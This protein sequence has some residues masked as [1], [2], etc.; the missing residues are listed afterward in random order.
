MRS[1]RLRPVSHRG[2]ATVA[3]VEST[4]REHTIGPSNSARGAETSSLQACFRPVSIGKSPG[5][6]IRFSIMGFLGG[7]IAGGVAGLLLAGSLCGVLA[8]LIDIRNS[9]ATQQPQSE[10]EGQDR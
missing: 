4:P 3:T 2:I 6:Q 5:N 1:V 8:V 7:F 9:V 10:R